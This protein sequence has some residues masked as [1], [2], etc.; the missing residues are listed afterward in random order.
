M[1]QY[2]IALTKNDAKRTQKVDFSDKGD[3]GVV[4]Y[5]S[6]DANKLCELSHFKEPL[7]HHLM[8]L[9]VTPTS[10]LL[11]GD[12]GKALPGVKDEDGGDV[13]L[14][15][16]HDKDC[17]FVTS[18]H[19][20][21][22]DLDPTKTVTAGADS[23]NPFLL[24]YSLKE[25]IRVK[26]DKGKHLKA[27]NGVH[28]LPLLVASKEENGKGGG[29]WR[30]EDGDLGYVGKWAGNVIGC[31]KSIPKGFTEI[32][33]FQEAVEEDEDDSDEDDSDEDEEPIGGKTVSSSRRSA[34]LSA[35]RRL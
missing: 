31:G 13:N 14:Y 12:Y 34:R 22:F 28:P 5:C 35:G 33:C 27:Y 24:N 3:K 29:D 8:S 7:V 11:V 16:L 19:G 32:K 30:A 2:W 20:V 9:I 26:D 4:A 18:P 10:L 1:G 15:M 6:Y 21:Y 17:F 23:K 25:C